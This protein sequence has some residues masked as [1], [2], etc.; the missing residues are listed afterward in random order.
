MPLETFASNPSVMAAPAKGTTF[1]IRGANNEVD[2]GSVPQDIWWL[3]VATGGIPLYPWPVAQLAV[4][5][6][7]SSPLDNGVVPNTGARTVFVEGLDTAFNT[8]SETVTLNGATGVVLANTYYRINRARVVTVGA[9]GVNAGDIQFD[10]PGPSPIGIIP[11]GWGKLSQ[12]VFTMPG[13][14]TPI[15]R[16]LVQIQMHYGIQ[17]QANANVGLLLR[18]PGESWVLEDFGNVQQTGDTNYQKRYDLG[19]GASLAQPWPPGT[20]FRIAAA[21]ATTNNLQIGAGM[22]FE[23]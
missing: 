11:A 6:A 7:S 20:D 1:L 21:N 19:F 2:I 16:N 8:V 18:L 15:R 17:P 12:C 14:L 10:H 5:V 23:V 13:D 3:G 22:D 4:T 9:G